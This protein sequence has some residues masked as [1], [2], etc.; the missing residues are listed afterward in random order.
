MSLNTFGVHS[1]VGQLRTVLVCRPGLAHER[2]TPANRADFLF[3]DVLSV[4]DARNNHRDF[5]LKLRERGIE[6]LELH[7]LLTDTL[8]DADARGWLLDRFVTKN[9]VGIGLAPVF[10]AWLDELPV[11]KLAEHLIGGVALVDLPSSART[12]MMVDALG[13]TEYILSPLPSSLFPRDAS[14][15]VSTGVTLNQLSSPSRHPETRLHR[16]VYKFHPRFKGG[17]F[18]VW[19]GDSDEAFGASVIHGRD[20]MAVG[21]GVVLVGLTERTTR[22]A[23][24]Q[25]VDVLFKHNAA[26]RVICCL[27]PKTQPVPYLDTV[28]SFCD[29]D[30][31]AASRDVADQVRCFSAWPTE[32]GGTVVREDKGHLFE[33][34]SEALGLGELRVV[35]TGGGDVLALAPGVVMGYDHNTHTNTLLRDA[36]LEVITIRGSELG[37]V[38]GGAHRLTCPVSRDPTQ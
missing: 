11:K 22:Q 10:R 33:V 17:D 31:C 12:S 13:A 21:H 7:D 24:F 32:A 5:V 18:T 26:T 34:I 4:P 38:Q 9:D 23:V 30:L 36:G 16:A 35:E 27:L 19:W 3:D 2:L 25:L 14:S 8:A 20:V 28:L 37:R 15:W 29:R 1:E 6:V